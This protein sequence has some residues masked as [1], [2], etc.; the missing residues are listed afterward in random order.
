MKKPYMRIAVETLEQAVNRLK[1]AE[2]ID[3][4][5]FK[6]YFLPKYFCCASRV[7]SKFGLKCF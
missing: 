4:F 6:S 1:Y 7:G 3:Q 5:N 2:K